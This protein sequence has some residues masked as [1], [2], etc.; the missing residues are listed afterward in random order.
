MSKNTAQAMSLEEFSAQYGEEANSDEAGAATNA[1]QMRPAN[2]INEE[3]LAETKVDMVDNALKS[4]SS[5][6]PTSKAIYDLGPE[7]L[8]EALAVISPQQIM[9]VTRRMMRN[10]SWRVYS[11]YN[12]VYTAQNKAVRGQGVDGHEVSFSEFVTDYTAAEYEETVPKA[13]LYERAAY[14]LYGELSQ[15]FHT[16]ETIVFGWM[17]DYQHQG[18][19]WASYKDDDDEWHNLHTLD[20]AIVR[21]EE[22]RAKLIER[23][24]GDDLAAIAK[25][26]AIGK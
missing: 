9:N 13:V 3:Q 12:T 26:A 7:F 1:E 24:R 18:L 4:A 20:E 16:A 8:F 15:A 6:D 14:E 25:I 5:I 10:I 21:F 22:E 23:R 19:P 2:E 17:D 11:A